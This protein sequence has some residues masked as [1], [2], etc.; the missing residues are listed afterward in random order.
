M[1][2]RTK[3]INHRGHRDTEDTEKKASARLLSDLKFLALCGSVLFCFWQA[4][5]PAGTP[6]KPLLSIDQECTA[7]SM[8]ADGRVV[9]A[10]RH[11][12]SKKKFQMERDDI[13]MADAGGRRRRIVEGEKL[14]RGAGPFSYQVHALRWSPDGRRLVADLETK[15]MN[16][17][18]GTEQDVEMGLLLDENGREIKIEGADSMIPGINV[19]WLAD[20]ATVGF[21]KE[22][23]KP[24]LT[25]S[26]NTVQPATG[27]TARLFESSAFAAAAWLAK[28]NL[29]VAVERDAQLSGQPVLVLLDVVKQTRK[30][31]A[32][33]ETF[34]GGLSISPSG[35]KVAYYK[36]LETLEVIEV[37]HPEKIKQV[38][39]LVG[40]YRWPPDE[41]RI[42]L[43]P[44]V[45][46]KSN[47]IELVNIAD[48]NVEPILHGLT[49]RDFDISPDGQ[50]VAVRIPGKGNIEVYPLR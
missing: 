41:R 3:K 12:F 26:L 11:T 37:A 7:F 43:K 42:L 29:V 33:L 47:V 13:W 45:E 20:G 22:E 30:E 14:I 19:E 49:F 8:A 34:S 10:V 9:Y 39:A 28:R 38:H 16:E 17:E 23:G 24:G 31:L 50:R 18:E 15:S 25:F 21:F 32:R 27:R 2:N 1:Q 5:A 44:G 36:D 35:E 4:A 46:N 6:E 48:G 40:A